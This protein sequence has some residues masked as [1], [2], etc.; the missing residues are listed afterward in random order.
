[1]KSLK[2]KL[3]RLGGPPAAP[4][5]GATSLARTVALRL[6]KGDAQASADELNGSCRVGEVALE[7][8]R[9]AKGD[10]LA[11]LALDASLADVDAERLVYLDTE[12]TGLSQGAGTLAFV[13]GLAFWRDA[14]LQV[15]QFVLKSPAEEPA[16]L[17]RLIERL[18]KASGIVTFN[19]KSFDV[20]LLRTRCVLSRVRSG[21]PDLPHFDLVHC[22]RRIFKRSL[23]SFRL[24][25]V[26]RAL[27]GLVRIGD[28]SGEEAPLRYFTYLRTKDM[29]HIQPVIEHNRLDVLSM[30]AIT[31]ALA[32][33]WNGHFSVAPTE[34]VGLAE[35]AHRYGDDERALS[36]AEEVSRAQV[37]PSLLGDAFELAARIHQR[38][39]RFAHATAAMQAA[40]EN[41]RA[42]GRAEDA[43]E[44]HLALAKALEHRMKQ[45]EE[46][47]AHAA[48][49]LSAEGAMLHER[50]LAR[51]KRKLSAK[52]LEAVT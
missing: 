42:C 14:K 7:M 43:S 51:L 1:M 31:G 3:S 48:K 45:P 50:R 17:R 12:T 2:D 23:S 11:A 18:D 35:T 22:C 47:I 6:E 36:W 8:G 38:S 34:R 49:T 26:E 4:S 27:A 33:A 30:V 19:G 20:P 16:I 13:I 41:F 24:T 37:A 25:A 9:A 5:T 32:A 29:R 52:E 21:L 44:M 28:I 46:A 40:L 10:A 39:G 15:E